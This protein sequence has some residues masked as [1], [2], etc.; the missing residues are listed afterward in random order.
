MD[1]ETWAIEVKFYRTKRA[2]ATL[3]EAA[4]LR[5]NQHGVR[6]QADKGM[7]VES[8]VLPI[9][10]R[11][12]LERNFNLTFVDAADLAIWAA[13]APDVLNELQSQLEVP[14]DDWQYEKGSDH[15]PELRDTNLARVLSPEVTKGS[16]LCKELRKLGRGRKHWLAYEELCERI[17]R[18]LFPNDLH[19]WHKQKRTDDGLNRYDFVCRVRTTTDFWKFVTQHLDSRYIIFEFKNY[20]GRIKQGQILTTEKYLFERALR[21]VAIIFSRSGAD[22][23]SVAMSQGAMREHGTL[24][25][26]LD[27]D[28]VCQMLHMKDRGN[29]P[30]DCLFDLADDFLLELPR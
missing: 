28:L 30:T 23:N 3:I 11:H 7:L 12:Q 13:E 6:G 1:K 22:K 20:S 16:D 24:M 27:D 2:Q 5:L 21:R 15:Q 19:G 10:L 9:K 14:P 26:I 18:Y 25:L 17:L 4:A 29:D 8:C